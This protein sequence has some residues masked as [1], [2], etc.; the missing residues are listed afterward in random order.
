M[1]DGL[2][3]ILFVLAA[4]AMFSVGVIMGY[5]EAI[6]RYY[7]G[8]PEWACEPPAAF[9]SKHCGDKTDD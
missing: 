4:V 3:A 1:N 7:S 8:G 6:D 9:L 5:S 2:I